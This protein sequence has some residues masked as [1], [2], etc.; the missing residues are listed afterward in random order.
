MK[1]TNTVLLAVKGIATAGRS[2]RLTAGDAERAPRSRRRVHK[3]NTHGRGTHAQP[4][5]KEK[6]PQQTR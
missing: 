5:K 3:Q 6:Y 4:R 1:V 2:N